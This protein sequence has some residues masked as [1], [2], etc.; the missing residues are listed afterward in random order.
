MDF[1][2]PTF[3]DSAEFKQITALGESDQRE[4]LSSS[5]PRVRVWAAWALGVRLS[6]AISP[7][8][9]QSIGTEPVA[10][11][12][13]HMLVMLAGFG[14]VDI[15]A[16]LAR[17]DPDEYVRKTAARFVGELCVKHP[18][19]F[20]IASQMMVDDDPAIRAAVIDGLPD[21]VPAHLAALLL[22]ARDDD[23]EIVREAMARRDANA[24]DVGT[25]KKTATTDP[26]AVVRRSALKALVRE[27][28]VTRALSMM[29]APQRTT[30]VSDLKAAR[31]RVTYDDVADMCPGP[32]Y[33]DIIESDGLG[34]RGRIWLLSLDRLFVRDFWRR[35][36]TA[37]TD[38]VVTDDD[39]REA[40]RNFVGEIEDSLRGDVARDDEEG[41]LMAWGEWEPWEKSQRELLETLRA[42][43]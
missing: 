20:V 3:L 10:G 18:D 29:S 41:A 13:R 33:L 14:E 16:A 6:D 7:E 35:V 23:S 12:R 4:L 40:I 1:N 19:A 27:C 15:V 38:V 42:L 2:D 37:Y 34:A 8:I 21:E 5:D 39:E 25:L 26:N 24:A 11:V 22:R 32:I 17:H 9:R 30:A 43:L 36:S 28:G 31:I